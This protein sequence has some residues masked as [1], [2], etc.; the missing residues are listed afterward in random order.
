ML[1]Y[2]YWCTYILTIG[3]SHASSDDSLSGCSSS[4]S[5]VSWDFLPSLDF[6]F[7]DCLVLGQRRDPLRRTRTYRQ[8][9]KRPCVDR[10]RREGQQARVRRQEV[11]VIRTHLQQRM[12]CQDPE[13]RKG[14]A[15]ECSAE[16]ESVSQA[17][18]SRVVSA[19]STAG[20]SVWHESKSVKPA[21]RSSAS[22]ATWHRGVA[23]PINQPDV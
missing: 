12:R 17:R 10:E 6:L 5:S 15:P 3:N 23:L 2:V 19:C 1:A 4:S 13:I 16:S 14:A 21:H 11:P 9:A 7:G 22:R 20:E 8:R 18:S